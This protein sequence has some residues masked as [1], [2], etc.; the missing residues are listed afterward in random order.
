MSQLPAGAPTNSRDAFAHI[1][2]VTTPTID[3]LKM[4]V[5]LEASGQSGYY[6]LASRADNQAI[7]KLLQANGREEL[8]H[9]HRVSKAIKLLTGEDFL[10][11]DDKDNPYAAPSGAR[12]DRAML[13]ILVT[14]ETNGCTMYEAWADTLDNP[15]AAALL[16]QN[17]KEETLHGNRAAEAIT[18]LA[19]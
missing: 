18:L 19:A 8:A 2:A 11:P 10:P 16:R 9:A 14:A 5:F 12:P 6:E 7:A 4:M 3:D 15:E 17:A 1:N 13:E